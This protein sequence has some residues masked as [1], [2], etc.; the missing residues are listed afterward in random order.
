VSVG[1]ISRKVEILLRCAPRV[2]R[3]RTSEEV[4]R[5]R[6]KKVWVAMRGKARGKERKEGRKESA[7]ELLVPRPTV[8]S[9]AILASMMV[10]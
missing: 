8:P 2:S 4:A 5:G 7:P 3:R 10:P 1:G 9:A 6:E